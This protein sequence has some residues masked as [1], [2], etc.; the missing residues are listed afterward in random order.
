[1]IIKQ[2]IWCK[3]IDDNN[4][5]KTYNNNSVAVIQNMFERSRQKLDLLKPAPKTKKKQ[6]TNNNNR[7]TKRKERKIDSNEDKIHEYMKIINN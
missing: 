7:K 3:P 6:N 5:N 2:S 1:M 4:N